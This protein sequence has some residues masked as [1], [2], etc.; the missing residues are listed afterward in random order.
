MPFSKGWSLAVKI[1][2]LMSALLLLALAGMSAASYIELRGSLIEI[3][4]ERLQRA[5]DQMAGVFGQSARQRVGAMKQLMDRPE[6]H[7]FLR[8][9]NAALTPQLH[10]DVQAYLGSAIAIANVELWDSNGQRIFASG[11]EFELLSGP[12]LEEYKQEFS[13]GDQPV[14]GKLRRVA[15]GLGYPVGG[16]VSE[17]GRVL[18]FVVE[19]RRITNPAQTRQTIAILTGLIGSEATMLIGN[20]DGSAWSDLVTAIDD[21]PIQ[22]GE[23]RL[24][25]YQRVGRPATLAWATPIAQSPWAVAIEFPLNVVLQPSRR[26]LLRSASIAT[27]LLLIV[28]AVA[29]FT[30]RRITTPLVQVT[31]AA[32]AVAE[33]KAH[34]HVDIDRADEIGRLAESFNTMA[35]KVEQA[36]TDLEL[37]VELRTAEL[38]AANRELEAF[39]YSV[40]HDL[41]APL[42]AIVGFVQILEEDH[43]ATLDPTARH[44][45]DRVKLNARRM[46]QLIDDLLSFSQIGRSTML[47]QT[48]D[49]HAMASAIAQEAIAASGRQVDLTIEPLP[50][51]YGEAALINQVFV[52][53]ISNAVKFTS[54]VSRPAVTIGVRE[55]DGETVYFVRDNGVGFDERYVEKLFGVFQ[56]L[57]RPDEFEG[58]GVGLAIVHRIISRHGGR[59][60]AEGKLGAGA[61]FYFTLPSSPK[62]KDEKKK[63]EARIA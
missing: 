57:H 28:G 62:T 18:G 39:S 6:V 8:T 9:H 32:E 42:R 61:T 52:N 19:R 33:S 10:A 11:A 53:L 49:M 4:T 58:T 41:R 31:E 29:W 26:F 47:R 50:Q 7:E 3:A 25:E 12:Q 15:D 54:R 37:R 56:R 40:S 36:R 48:I 60:W 27:A 16:R 38:R 51:A 1:P 2:L 5:A 34:V 46:G 22:G 35:E 63:V 17:A 45:L 43:A 24:W 13:A 14:I 20:T 44:H 30:S 21:L 59:V 55:T 23:A